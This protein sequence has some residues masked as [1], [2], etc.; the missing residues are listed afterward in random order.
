[1]FS[2]YDPTFGCNTI[3][4]TL[5]DISDWHEQEQIKEYKGDESP[6]LYLDEG[7][8]VLDTSFLLSDRIVGWVG[9]S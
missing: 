2:C 8:S 1:M 5:C 7:E 6:L 9:R 4:V 3:I